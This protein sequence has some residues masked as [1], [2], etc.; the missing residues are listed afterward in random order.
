[1]KVFRMLKL[2]RHFQA[3]KVL[4]DTARKVWRQILGMVA[5]LF[6]LTI[7]FAILLFEVEIG[8]KCFIGDSNC[9]AA[10]LQAPYLH[11][12]SMVSLNEKKKISQ[13]S[14]V[15]VGVWFSFVSLT[16]T[17]YGDVIPVTDMGKFMAIFLL[18]SG[19]FYLAMP[20]TAAATTFYN[21][22]ETYEDKI[23]HHLADKEKDRPVVLE[24]I[25]KAGIRSLIIRV[26]NIQHEANSLFAHLQENALISQSDSGKKIDSD[27]SDDDDE[28]EIETKK[29]KKKSKSDLLKK[30]NKLATEVDSMLCRYESDLE[31]VV[32]FN[33]ERNNILK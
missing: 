7:L 18:I 17:G 19:T 12:G 28:N 9:E 1:M 26:Q 24:E 31:K 22:H 20:L 10:L 6:F 29:T 32:R 33:V 3:S 8:D 30:M 23:G 4:V 15:F 5:L 11:V 14:N 27:S 2:T 16:S 25:T 21:V 13:F